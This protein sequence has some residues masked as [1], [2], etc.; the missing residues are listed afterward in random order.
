M[1]WYLLFEWL[2]VL[3][4]I[5]AVGSNSTTA[6]WMMLARQK[7]EAVEFTLKGIKTIDDKIANRA[8]GGLLVT[9]V[10][11]LFIAPYSLTTPWL[12]ISLILYAGLLVVGLAGYSPALRSQIKAVET[13]GF[14][15][16]DITPPRIAAG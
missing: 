15:S 16:V 6:V 1:I 4:A 13:N 2:H 12:L 7:P 8:Y 10:I 14:D 5:L 3:F 11:M 9:G